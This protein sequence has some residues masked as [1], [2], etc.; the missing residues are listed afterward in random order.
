MK[1]YLFSFKDG[2]NIN[3]YLAY[4]RIKLNIVLFKPKDLKKL[5]INSAY[6]KNLNY[7]LIKIYIAIKRNIVTHFS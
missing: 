2:H 7:A 6:G 1:R 5:M 4:I 3:G